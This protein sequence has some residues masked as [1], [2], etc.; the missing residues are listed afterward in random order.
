MK[1]KDDLLRLA[2]GELSADAARA[3]EA[4]ASADARA[5]LAS[6]RDLRASLERLPTPPPEGLSNDRLRAAILDRELRT[7]RAAPLAWAWAPLALAAFAG[8]VLFARPAP[9]SAPQIVSM[10]TVHR[11]EVALVAPDFQPLSS[12]DFG[13]AEP[14]QAAAAPKAAPQAAPAPHRR[15]SSRSR[16]ANVERIVPPVVEVEP[17][18]KDLVAVVQE[19][20]TIA[21]PPSALVAPSPGAVRGDE[22]VVIVSGK[23][24][25]G[26]GAPAATETEASN[27][28]VGG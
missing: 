16:K 14:P 27:V 9:R 24:D 1:K 13:D 28:L 21:A 25:L 10:P 15:Q 8:I 7:R 3:V 22:T 20:E 4:G 2:F 26:T 23:R 18:Q 11:D 6:L 19:P 12:V 5:E 17:Q